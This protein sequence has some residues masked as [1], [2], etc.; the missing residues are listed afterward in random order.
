MVEHRAVRQTSQIS[1]QPKEVD[2]FE[3]DSEEGF[4]IEEEIAQEDAPEVE[5]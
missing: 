2:D 1:I 5:G 3:V 4:V